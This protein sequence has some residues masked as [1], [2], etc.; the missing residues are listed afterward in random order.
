[1]MFLFSIN[2][3]KRILM[4]TLQQF[5]GRAVLHIFSILPNHRQAAHAASL[6]T[7]GRR[8]FH[9][10]QHCQHHHH[11]HQFHR[12]WYHWMLLDLLKHVQLSNLKC[13]GYIKFPQGTQTPS[14]L[15]SIMFLTHQLSI[16]DN[17]M[18]TP[19]M[20][21][22]RWP[23]W[24]SKTPT[25]PNTSPQTQLLLLWVRWRQIII[26]I[27]MMMQLSRLVMMMC[28]RVLEL[29]WYQHDWWLTLRSNTGRL[30]FFFS[31]FDHRHH[32]L[33]GHHGHLRNLIHCRC[34]TI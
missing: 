15:S 32:L 31:R 5:K 2:I 28:H 21:T 4:K 10:H 19:S 25:L 13:L 24:P 11:H 20:W 29:R 17:T 18:T 26:M 6:N 1:M 30:G 7:G 14:S 8:C 23:T 16:I 9:L 12:Q 22:S 27:M 33:H 3:F 34:E